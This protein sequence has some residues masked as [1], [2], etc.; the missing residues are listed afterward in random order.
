MNKNKKIV[1]V[2]VGIIVLVGVFYGGMI[3]GKGQSSTIGAAQNRAGQFGGAR[4]VRTTGANGGFISGQVLSKDANSIT[5]QLDNGP[6]VA[7]ATATPA[8]SKI[9]FLDT[10]TAI[11][12]TATGSLTDLATGTQVSVTGTTNPDGS[13]TAKNIQIRPQGRPATPTQ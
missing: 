3:Y 2:I 7:G 6:T 12:K 5:V 9:I 10:S 1:F 4:G 11:T 8:G 13:V